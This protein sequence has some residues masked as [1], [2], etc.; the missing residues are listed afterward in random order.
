[1]QAVVK[2]SSR[3]RRVFEVVIAEICY[4]VDY[5]GSIVKPE[6]VSVNGREV[7]KKQR[8]LGCVLRFSFM[9]GEHSTLLEVRV[10][11]WTSLRAVHLWVDDDLIY[12]EGRRL[13]TSPAHLMEQETLDGGRIL[14]MTLL[15][16]G[17][18]LIGIN[19]MMMVA[20]RFFPVVLAFSP[21]MLFLGIAGV[22]DPR[23]CLFGK[24]FAGHQFP[25]WTKL[26]GNSLLVLGIAVGIGLVVFFWAR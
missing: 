22:I 14:A 7:D 13:L 16:F 3:N 23:I 20:G 8:Q 18:A 25:F 17:V 24:Q 2:E 10:W 15:G 6:T 1:M 4:W 9:L 26:L 5:Q 19:V 11:P 21:V 12:S